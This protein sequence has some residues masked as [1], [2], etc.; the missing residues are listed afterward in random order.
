MAVALFTGIGIIATGIVLYAVADFLSRRYATSL[1]TDGHAVLARSGTPMPPKILAAQ[2]DLKKTASPD[3]RQLACV[4]NLT[5]AEAED[6][7]D[8]LEANG[9]E[10]LGFRFRADD[11]YE[12][13]FKMPRNPS[14]NQEKANAKSPRRKE[15]EETSSPLGGFARDKS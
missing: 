1:S 5:K 4:H 7:L 9:Y 13:R 15:R 12:V 6:L 3:D 8:W 2:E 10:H 14:L 11:G